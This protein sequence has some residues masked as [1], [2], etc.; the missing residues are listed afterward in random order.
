MNDKNQ[1]FEAFKWWIL[2]PPIKYDLSIS[3]EEREEWCDYSF[4][5]RHSIIYYGIKKDLWK[6]Y[7]DF[8]I[9]FNKYINNIHNKN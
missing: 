8:C 7:E 1:Y 5:I 6:G 9:Q 4:Y 3:Y 2:Y